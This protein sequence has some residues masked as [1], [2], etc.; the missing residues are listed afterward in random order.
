L[1]S[2][3]SEASYVL[4]R[5]ES[6]GLEVLCVLSASGE[7]TLPVF[8]SRKAARRFLRFGPLRFGLLG[9]GWRVR[10]F[11]SEELSSLLIRCR[12]SVRRVALDPSPE[13]LAGDHVATRT[14][15]AAESAS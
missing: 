11:S 4:A 1:T 7:R 2:G 8:A 10:G 12:I 6:D 9:S 5:Q 15:N 14:A 3:R 13:A